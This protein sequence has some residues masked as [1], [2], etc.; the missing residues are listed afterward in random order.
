MAVP[1]RAALVEVGHHPDAPDYQ[2]R[3]ASLEGHL[4]DAPDLHRV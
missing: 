4:L 2:A 1:L 3:Q